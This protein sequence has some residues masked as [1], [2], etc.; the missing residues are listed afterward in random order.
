MA[1]DWN[2]A[3]EKHRE[4]LK[5]VLAT[6][7][8]MAGFP[9][10]HAGEGA[11]VAGG[12]LP[13]HIHSALVALLRPAEA[14]ARRLVIVAARGLVVKPTPPRPRKPAP[15][16]IFLRRGE[17]GTGIVLPRGFVPP[18]GFM[19]PAGFTPKPPRPGFRLLDPLPR[20]KRRVRQ[21]A[22]PRISVPGF[23]TPFAL[24]PRREP[25]PHDPIDAAR[26]AL[27]LKA[28]G[29]VLDDL[30]R[31]ARRFAR[32]RAAGRA[33]VAQEKS[34]ARPARFRRTWPLRPG[35]PPGHHSKR[36]RRPAHAVHPLLDDLQ[37]LAFWALNDTS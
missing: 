17:R 7:V 16:S 36:S 12:T 24:A 8:A 4:A 22:V 19:K 2:F 34:G 20:W 11:A 21:T 1:L 27:R 10:L 30:P 3:I 32:W 29:S 28:L 9:V 37:L 33:A 13:R 5:R 15:P 23:T 14:A 31:H 26:L 25:S 6:L 35:R 18:P